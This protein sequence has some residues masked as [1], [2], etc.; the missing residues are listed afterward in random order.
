M[1]R[2][3]SALSALLLL[4]VSVSL[5]T[6]ATTG[7]LVDRQGRPVAG[8]TVRALPFETADVLAARLA[9]GA[10]AP[11]PLASATSDARG[12]FA[13]DVDAPYF[14]LAIEAKGFAP[15]IERAERNELVGA[16]L[17]SEADLVTI[18]IEGEGNAVAG[19]IVRASTAKP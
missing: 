13:L 1:I 5:A 6:A 3:K 12:R 14:R 15:L 16:F 18:A 7:A 8:A 19:A 11:E 17:L 2:L 10:L 9:S 4:L